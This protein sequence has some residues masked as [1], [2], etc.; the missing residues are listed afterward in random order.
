MPEQRR[1]RHRPALCRPWG[2]SRAL[3]RAAGN[4]NLL[5]LPSI[6]KGCASCGLKRGK[7]KQTR[8]GYCRETAPSSSNKHS[9]WRASPQ[10][11]SRYINIVYRGRQNRGNT[12]QRHTGLGSAGNGSLVVSAHS[13]SSRHLHSHGEARA[14][15]QRSALEATQSHPAHDASFS[16]IFCS[17]IGLR[18][19][20]EPPS[21]AGG[22]G[23]TSA[24][25]QEWKTSG[26][27]TQTSRS[28]S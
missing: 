22:E 17:L 13:T 26:R 25:E 12:A 1:G 10:G 18:G 28:L 5:P 11:N 19:L 8:K 20:A 6:S 24:V 2:D 3:R 14:K 27:R 15:Q 23:Q 4:T 7:T 9:I 16:S 21:R